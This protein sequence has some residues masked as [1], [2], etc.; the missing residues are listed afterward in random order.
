MFMPPFG[1]NL[2]A[3]NALFKTPLPE[4]YR[5]VHA[6]PA[7]LS[8]DADA[9]HLRA[10]DH[11]RAAGAVQISGPARPCPRSNAGRARFSAPGYLFGTAPNAF[12]KSKADLLKAKAPGKALSIADGEARNG[13]FMAEQGL[14]VRLDRQFGRCA[15][16]GPQA[17]GGARRVSFAWSAAT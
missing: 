8:G 5:G 10:G 17:R 11:A 14:D 4:L 3:A 2:F 9:D 6:V 1:L 7:D 15:G 13:V 12:L 16:E